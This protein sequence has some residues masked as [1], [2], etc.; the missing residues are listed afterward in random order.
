MSGKV[1]C[2]FGSTQLIKSIIWQNNNKQPIGIE[3]FSDLTNSDNAG[4][5]INDNEFMYDTS[6]QKCL[7]AGD[8][9]FDIGQEICKKLIKDHPNDYTDELFGNLAHVDVPNQTTIKCIGRVS[10]DNNCQ[11][12]KHSTLLIGADEMK[13][14]TVKLNFNRMKAFSLFPGQTVYVQGLNP[15]GDTL[16]VDEIASERQLSYANGL[17]LT[18]Q[19]SLVVANGPFTLADDLKYQPLHELLAYCS[20]NKPDVLI[21]LGPIIDCDHQ[22]VIDCSSKLSYES[23][24]ENLLSIIADAIGYSFITFKNLFITL[25]RLSPVC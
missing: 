20:Q 15:R 19:L 2:T 13:L 25:L 9:I 17:K 11:L 8:R 7:I 4:H 24:F 21:L 22:H 18:K 16:F 5:L 12:D 3:I 23:I 10:S 6:Q 14:R 1:V